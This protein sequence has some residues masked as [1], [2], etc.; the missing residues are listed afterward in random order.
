MGAP[1]PPILRTVQFQ[2]LYTDSAD[3]DVRNILYF[4]YSN[5]MSAT[6]LTTL[7]NNMKTQWNTHMASSTVPNVLLE[8]VFANDLSSDFAPQAA[9][10]LAAF[11]GTNGGTKLTSG[12]AFVISNETGLKYRGGHSRNYLPGIPENDLLDAN[13]W[14][15]AAQTAIL[16]AWTAFLSA[17]IQ[18]A[19][20]AAVGTLVH[21]VAHRFGKTPDAPVLAGVSASKSVPLTSPFTTP[22]SAYRTNP[23]VGSQRRRNQQLF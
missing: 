2:L 12:A 16:N 22:I 18:T 21:V 4:T 14:S 17:F 19:V 6:D 7:C 5:S 1:L 23:Q 11:P 13:T 9:D 8:E 15:T 3:T 10:T 20:P